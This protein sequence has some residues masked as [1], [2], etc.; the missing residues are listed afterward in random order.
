MDTKNR[1]VFARGGVG[2]EKWLEGSKGTNFSCYKTVIQSHRDIIHSMVTIV[3]NTVL[4]IWK[5][6]KSKS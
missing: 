2:E 6:V 4:Y 3:N 5:L 1:L